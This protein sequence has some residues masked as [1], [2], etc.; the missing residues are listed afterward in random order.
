[1]ARTAVKLSR[2]RR[3]GFA[4]RSNA[5]EEQTMTNAGRMMGRAAALIV[6]AAVMIAPAKAQ[7]AGLGGGD[8]GQDMMTQT[9][10]MLN[11]MKAKMGKRRFGTLMQ[12]M[13][14]MM[15][16]MM[17]GGGTGGLGGSFAGSG[18]ITGMLGG[19]GSGEMTAMIPQLVSLAG[20]G[21]KGHRHH[22]HH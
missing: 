7:I 20:T 10:P 13:G 18:D 14:P 3:Q 12:T 6:L 9:A 22:R 11:M 15:G 19:A 16:N 4:P 21:G 17:Q 5:C 8:G 1:M 2:M